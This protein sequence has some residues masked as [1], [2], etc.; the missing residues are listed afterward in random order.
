MNF[1]RLWHV[2]AVDIRRNLKRPLF[3]ILLLIIGLSVWGVVV[4][5]RNGYD[6]VPAID[7][8][9]CIPHW[10]GERC[11]YAMAIDALLQRE[12]SIRT[13]LNSP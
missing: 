12:G 11:D 6:A 8:N 13:C 5:G 1:S 4:A 7:A 9:T 2:A 3:W 10:E